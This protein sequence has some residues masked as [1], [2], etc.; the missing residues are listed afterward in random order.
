M[1]RVNRNIAS[2]GA[3]LLGLVLSASGCCTSSLSRSAHEVTRVRYAASAVYRDMNGQT[4]AIQGM[5]MTVPDP[6]DAS[7]ARPPE[8]AD[9][10]HGAGTLVGSAGRRPDSR[11]LLIP[12]DLVA[13]EDLWT[14]LSPTN[15]GAWLDQLRAACSKAMPKENVRDTLPRNYEK[16][17]DL[18]AGTNYLDLERGPHP[19]RMAWLPV[20]VM[21][22]IALTPL[23]IIGL[24]IWI[25][26][27]HHPM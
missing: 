4:I 14:G 18:P 21:G 7:S 10:G 1:I 5:L 17:A 8:S 20:A 25:I 3:L 9:A 27:G 11:Y 13:R 19:G 23:Y 24:P 16:V 12:H 22:D 2:N 26:F 6:R 15:G